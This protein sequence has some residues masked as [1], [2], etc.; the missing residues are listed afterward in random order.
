MEAD[1]L[2]PPPAH[3]VALSQ[4]LVRNVCMYVCMYV[5]M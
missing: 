1:N 3:L 2:P 4:E 5:C